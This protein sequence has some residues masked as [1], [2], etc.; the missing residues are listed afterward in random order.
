[1]KYDVVEMS[2]AASYGDT[3]PQ[4]LFLMT[5]PIHPAEFEQWPW[6]MLT[7]KTSIDCIDLRL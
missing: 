1:M 3:D 2:S 7:L 5:L 4:V 6:V